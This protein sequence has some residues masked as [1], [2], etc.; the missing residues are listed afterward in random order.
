M[1]DSRILELYWSRSADA[2]DEIATKCGKSC[3]SIAYNIL[4]NREDADESV[5]DTYLGAWNSMPPHRPSVLATFLGKITRRVSLNK[6]KKRRRDKRGGREIDL[7]FEELSECLSSNVNDAEQS[8]L[9]REL[10]EAIDRFLLTLATQERNAFICR[11]WFLA[12]IAEI[13]EK[14]GFSQSKTKTM[15]SRSRKKLQ[16]QMQEEGF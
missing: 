2:I 12:S 3:H 8:V 7:A 10:K 5:D 4:A 13:S 9:F 1:E 14:F 6:W 11:Y 16:F 15:L